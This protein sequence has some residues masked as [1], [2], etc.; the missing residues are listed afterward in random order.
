MERDDIDIVDIEKRIEVE[1]ASRLLRALGVNS[2]LGVVDMR[3]GLIQYTYSK[4]LSLVYLMMS[5]VGWM[6]G[7]H[8]RPLI[9]L[10]ARVIWAPFVFVVVLWWQVFVYLF[11]YRNDSHTGRRSNIGL[12][13]AE[14]VEE[15]VT[16]VVSRLSPFYPWW[17]TFEFLR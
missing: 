10:W 9:L 1:S 11:L 3:R 4:V 6:V 16:L 15:V 7:C 5:D 13:G 17:A 8:S 12:E 2:P 14:S